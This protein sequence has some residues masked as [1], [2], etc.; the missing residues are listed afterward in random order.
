M[1]TAGAQAQLISFPGAEGAGR[2]TSGGRGTA[3]T[4]TTVFEVTDL[5][6]DGQPGSLRYALTTAA[7][8][9]TVVFRVS[10]T[11]HLTSELR[12]TRANTTIAGQ[13]APG[14]GICL[15]D[16]PVT[17]SADNVIIRFI[18]CRLGDKNQ[19]KGKVNGSGDG[20]AFG[21]LGRKNIM[22][23]H[24]TMSWSSDEACTVYRGD[25]TT[26]QWNIISEPLD[27]S[28]HFE[29][30]DSDYERHAYGGIW[31]GRTASFHHNL[32]A[33][34][35]GRMPRFDGSRNLSPNT[36]GQENADFRNNVVYNWA[37]YNVNGGEGGNYNIVNNYYKYGPNT[38]TGSSGGV[39]VRAEVLT[40]YK[41]NSSP[42]LPYG[43]FYL[44]GNYVE[45][46][47]AVTN[48]NWLGVVMN[49]GTRADTAVAKVTAPFPLPAINTQSAQDAYTAV[50]Q[51]AGCVL[52]TR[53]AL[54]QRIVQD[55]I[56][57][58]G[59]LIDVQG[60]YAH[61]TPYSTSQAAWP[62]LN[63]LP[64]PTDTDHDGMPDTWETA[65]GL[66]PNNAADRATRGSSGYT[67]LE[68]YLNSL[69]SA[70]VLAATP[71]ATP[72]VAALQAYPNPTSDQLTLVHPAAQR[73]A[74]V[75]VYNS[76]GQVVHTVAV[77]PGTVETQLSTATLAPGSYLLRYA[78]G[79]THL[80]TR[81]GR[82]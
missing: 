1:L 39:P 69:T 78:D 60:G 9:R 75:Q 43:K 47:P 10:G 66:D 7:A 70:V 13:T 42:V 22:V 27:Y 21:G 81:I 56:N 31:G 59:S 58:T 32:L 5:N 48:R 29:T 44:A 55:V 14:D 4:P 77:T 35:R 11:I 51:R 15:A 6:D 36:A 71:A 45:S 53:D 64:A 50:L 25:S 38:G 61:G 72:A 8:Y 40:P 18:R 63:S 33:H 49:G 65:R 79:A 57:R 46:S 26:L 19:D 23:D 12:I 16:F 28:Y 20:D 68:E 41:Q 30:G 34:M 80:T 52:P 74:L 24:C 73:G 37:S 82:Q 67:A 17:V 2:F 3:T 76:L 62:V 54:D